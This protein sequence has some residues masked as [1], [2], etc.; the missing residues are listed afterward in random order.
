ML[1][2]HITFGQN[3]RSN[4]FSCYQWW[5]KVLLSKPLSKQFK[6]DAEYQHRRQN[7]PNNDANL[8]EHT[9]FN[10]VRLHLFYTPVKNVE[11]SLVP[12]AYFRSQPISITSRVSDIYGSEYRWAVITEITNSFQRWDIKYRV[13]YESRYMRLNDNKD[14]NLS[15]RFRMRYRVQYNA[16][17]KWSLYIFDE[18]FVNHDFPTVFDQN[19]IW[20]GFVFSGI[21]KVKL[22]C[23]F[24]NLVRTKGTKNNWERAFT[25]T[26]SYTL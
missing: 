26:F 5:G 20:G 23:G 10:C 13:G 15:G 21:P 3:D 2:I 17:K 12:F 24:V 7:V 1:P 9:T 6:L 11:F 14:F 18:V 22:D 16:S 8:F 25:T 19:R 4:N